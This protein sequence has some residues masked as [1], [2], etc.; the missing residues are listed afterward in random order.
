MTDRVQL[1]Y[2]CKSREEALRRVERAE[3]LEGKPFL[4]LPGSPDPE[5]VAFISKQNRAVKV[6]DVEMVYND[7]LLMDAISDQG[8]DGPLTKDTY[9]ESP[10]GRFMREVLD[11]AIAAYHGAD[12]DHPNGRPLQ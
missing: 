8:L 9:G 10:Q 11:W 12:W 2:R 7:T 5:S 1:V 3:A 4:S 6:K